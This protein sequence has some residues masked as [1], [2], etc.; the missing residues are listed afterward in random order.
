MIKKPDWERL[1]LIIYN[2]LYYQ[3]NEP[4]AEK[5]EKKIKLFRQIREDNAKQVAVI[6]LQFGMSPKQV[7]EIVG[8]GNPLTDNQIYNLSPE[9]DGTENNTSTAEKDSQSTQSTKKSTNYFSRYSPS[10]I[11]S[12]AEQRVILSHFLAEYLNRTEV[13]GE[14]DIPVLLL[15]WD[16]TLNWTIQN[17]LNLTSSR[18]DPKYLNLGIFYDVARIANGQKLLNESKS[19][20]MYLDRCP[21]CGC[22]YVAIDT[23]DNIGADKCCFCQLYESSSRPKRKKGKKENL[24]RIDKSD[25]EKG[26]VTDG[27]TKSDFTLGESEYGSLLSDDLKTD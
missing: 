27:E 15:A 14:V 20:S 2:F 19:K 13:T 18:W 21:V 10:D 5:D 8:K 23:I 9:R 25:G 11:P 16:A 4:P 3:N 17:K 12:S 24:T 7:M 1:R 22:L 6:L 26:F